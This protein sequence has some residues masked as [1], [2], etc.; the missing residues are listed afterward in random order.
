M[1]EINDTYRRTQAEAYCNHVRGL[2]IRCEDEQDNYHEQI[3][4][5][6]RIKAIRHYLQC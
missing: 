3:D 6:Y 5:I 2:N 4:T 1:T